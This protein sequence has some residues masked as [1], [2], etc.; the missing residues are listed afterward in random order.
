LSGTKLTI[1]APPMPCDAAARADDRRLRSARIDRAQRPAASEAT[2]SV[3]FAKVPNVCG[4]KLRPS[5]S[6]PTLASS[7]ATPVLLTV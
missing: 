7:V 3:P 5:A 4:A 6:S 2:K 1:S